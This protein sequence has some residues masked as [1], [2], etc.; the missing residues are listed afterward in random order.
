MSPL[1]KKCGIIF[2][3][4]TAIFALAFGLKIFYSEEIGVVEK[5][6]MIIGAM[7][8]INVIGYCVWMKIGQR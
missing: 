3:I 5:F 6:I 1:L 8:Y 2:W 7:F 4:F